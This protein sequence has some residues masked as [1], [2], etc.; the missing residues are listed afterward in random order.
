MDN[1]EIGQQ[2]FT[3]FGSS[4]LETATILWIFQLVG[5]FKR[6]DGAWGGSLKASAQLHN[7]LGEILFILGDFLT[8]TE[9]KVFLFIVI[10]IPTFLLKFTIFTFLVYYSYLYYVAITLSSLCM[11]YISLAWLDILPHKA[12]LQTMSP[13][14]EE[15]V[16]TQ[17]WN[18]V[19]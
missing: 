5:I 3:E 2:F 17:V 12:V 16:A 9:T 18:Y 15:G 14:T 6:A 11:D 10:A 7:T 4:A 8:S 19:L 1:N 13:C